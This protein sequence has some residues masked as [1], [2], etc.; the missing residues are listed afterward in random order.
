MIQ[1]V[2]INGS[3]TDSL[4]GFPTVAAP[5]GLL[6][7]STNS[8]RHYGNS[9]CVIPELQVNVGW[10]VTSWLRAY[11]GYDFLFISNVVRPG[12]QI[13]PYVN[14]NLLPGFSGGK[15]LP[16]TPG[17]PYRPAFQMNR[18]DFWAQG[19]TAGVQVRW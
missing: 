16:P 13:D 2:S 6:A 8:G 3:T 17:G 19:V 14:T 12:N 5:G 11:V 9:F 4:P 18:T 10:N 7:R 1:Q 15:V